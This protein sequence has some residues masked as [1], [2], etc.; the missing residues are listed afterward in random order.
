VA[1]ASVQSAE[2]DRNFGSAEVLTVY[3]GGQNEVGRALIRFNLAAALPPEASIDEARLE[4]YQQPTEASTAV[5]LSMELVTEDWV[6][7][8]VTW[9]SKPASGDPQVQVAVDAN[10]GWKSLEMTSIARAWHNAPH[11]GLV[12]SGPGEETA[13]ERTFE[14]RESGDHP[15]RLVVTYHLPPPSR[16]DFEG[17]V[18]QGNPSQTGTPL[19]DVTVELYGDEDEW[20][21]N[22]A[23]A[24]LDATTTGAGGAFSLVYQGEAFPFFHVVEVDPPG[25][26]S[27]GARAEAP[28]T[29]TEAN[30]VTFEE[31]APGRYEGIA[32]WDRPWAGDC[33][34]VLVNGDFETGSFPP[35][36]HDGQVG[37][38]QAH[39][40]DHGAWL[41]GAD[42]LEAEVWQS[43][44]IP[45]GAE[46]VWLTF[47]WRAETEMEQPGDH[48]AVALQYGEEF[49][50]LQMLAGTDPLG[51]WRYGAVDLTAYA[52]QEVSATFHAHTD[53][54]VPT[55][56]RVDDV[57]LRSCGIGLPDLA[58]ANLWSEEGRI[59][60]EIT[61]G[62]ES[63]APGGHE[64]ALHVDGEYQASEE[65]AEA[66]APGERW[67]SCFDYE[68]SC[69]PPE[70]E[71]LIWTDYAT[72]IEESD[73]DN[74]ARAESWD[75]AFPDLEIIAGPTVSEITRNSAVVTW[76]T[77]LDSDSLVRYGVWERLFDRERGDLNLVRE[78]RITLT[79]LEPFAT[80]HLEVQSNAAGGQTVTSRDLTFETQALPDA[81]DPWVSL[82]EP[83]LL[84]DLVT[85][86]ADAGDDKG[87][88]RVEFYLDNELVLTDYE[89]PFELSLRSNDYDNGTHDLSAKAYD[90]SGRWSDSSLPVKMDNF[91]DVGAPT[92]TIT[93]H[94][95]QEHVSGVITIL[96]TLSDDAG[97]DSARFYVD[98]QYTEYTTFYPSFPKG[99]QTS[100][101]WDTRGKT[102]Q[103]NLSVEAKDTTSKLGWHT[104]RLNVDAWQPPPPPAYPSLT[105]IDHTVTRNQGD[106]YITVGLTVKNVGDADAKNV[107]IVDLLVGFQAIENS[108]SAADYVVSYNP[109]GMNGH[110]EI[111]PK[112]DIP[113]GATR[114][115]SYKAV[116]VMVHPQA[117]SWKPE[118]G[119]VV[120]MGYES[121]GNTDHF[122]IVKKPVSKTKSGESLLKAYQEALRACD[123]LLV[124]NPWQLFALFSPSYKQGST[125][126]SDDVNTLLS[127]MARLAYLKQGALGYIH[128]YTITG[129]KKLI[130]PGGAWAKQLSS[131]FSTPL[132]GYLLI[133]GEQEIVPSGKTSNWE[134]KW[135]DGTTTD[136]VQLGDQYYSNTVGYLLHPELNVGRAI[137]DKPYLLARPLWTSIGVEEGTSGFGFD[138]SHALLLSGTGG[139]D[140]TFRWSINETHKTLSGRGV[141]VYKIHGNTAPKPVQDFTSH[142]SG[143]D[144]VCIQGH[145]NPDKAGPVQTT[146]FS[147]Q[148]FGSANPVVFVGACLS[149]C[150][151]NHPKYGGGDYNIAE[152]FFD[153]GAGVFIGSTE[154]SSIQRYAWA[155]SCLFILWNPAAPMTA[156]R[157]W[158]SLE[159]WYLTHNLGKSARFFIYEYNLYGDPKFGAASSPTVAAQPRTVQAPPSS[160]EITI[161]DYEVTTEDGLD[162]VEI[163]GGGL[164]QVHGR[165]EVP[166]YA[167]S[168]DLPRGYQVQDVVLAERT[169]RVTESGLEI[170][171][172]IESVDRPDA[173]APSAAVP[174]EGWFP[175]EDYD[176]QVA[177]NP[178]GTTTLR[179][180]VYPFHYDPASQ[181]AE[182]YQH[183]RFDVHHRL[184]EVSIT[185]LETSQDAY[186]EGEA[187]RVDLTLKNTGEAQDVVV[188]ASIQRHGSGEWVDGLLLRTL[189]GLRG[190][191]SFA[192]R[193]DNDGFPAGYYDVVVTLR[194]SAGNLLDESAETFKVGVSAGEI[195]G[196]SAAPTYFEPGDDIDITMTFENVGTVVISGTAMINVVDEAGLTVESFSHQ[197]AALT[198]GQEVQLSD[199]WDTSAMF[200]TMA[201]RPRPGPWSSAPRR[202]RS[203]CR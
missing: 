130:E 1:D 2:P 191:A 195:T 172:M 135:S 89:P 100:F 28:G 178:D 48:L 72:Q 181:E 79:G 168:I 18:Y 56:F 75:C 146:H 161:P 148:T 140:S 111:R 45:G 144:L 97:L 158:S 3:S 182:F 187:V 104:I 110:C 105:L 80:Y 164:L 180:V 84:R 121:P 50:L 203:T 170:P 156:G 151:E 29:V 74:N 81:T 162:H 177:E 9:D 86:S 69:S 27:T 152:A 12:V 101:E 132:G 33:R 122:N 4:L 62:G 136:V 30:V 55:T 54:E 188:R 60:Y 5:T 202:C 98:G 126:A 64:T 14:S 44:T 66:L 25:T 21:H 6:E 23:R 102:G 37:L 67:A 91:K 109:W 39:G 199:V 57:S 138:A 183:F 179:I 68:W 32:F 145:G 36:G 85:V 61:N 73:E 70:D 11:Y 175:E 52:G 24:F 53:G 22:G 128:Q 139:S 94:S 154:L 103:H 153:S 93:S 51:E 190:T 114:I 133:V 34:E 185:G 147:S 112:N 7:A 20:P 35:W 107:S 124:T 77:N 171:I 176:W 31:V 174:S 192:P 166:A 194:D 149:G 99:V 49:D 78:H 15:P 26:Y 143:R 193:W 83:G 95:D 196:F 16:Y 123:Y 129:L 142:M 63:V 96:A 17:H 127:T 115:Y 141:T 46:P 42:G 167:T 90:A 131:T 59:C 88:E 119:G 58:V 200:C 92:V 197:V 125:A 159:T 38:G 113:K 157:A 13:Y 150:Y 43:V 8:G 116:P 87:V 10:E 65:V 47:W 137:G 163:P 173:L 108:T 201:W 184:S 198:P 155:G 71:I 165:P 134:Q 40:G 41:G 169:G 76:E 189:H 118:V 19:G 82:V 120:D 106:N 117:A 160:V 186:A